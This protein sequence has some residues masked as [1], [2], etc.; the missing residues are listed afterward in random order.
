MRKR[1]KYK[2]KP[3]ILDTMS[4]VMSGMKQMTNLKDQLIALQLKNH[5]ALE[6]LRLGQATKEDIDTLINAFNITEALAKQKIGDDYKTEIKE[7]QDALFACAK[8]G[9]ENNYRFVMKGTELKAINYVM[10]IHDAQLEASTVKDIELATNYVYKCLQSKKAR[11][12]IEG[13]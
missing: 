8:R 13:V 10:E 3:V 2:P 9:V 4:Y 12:V 6:A 1:S 5:L 11:P 7:A